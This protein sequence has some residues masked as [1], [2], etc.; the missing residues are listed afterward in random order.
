ML[1]CINPQ[2]KFYAFFMR[3]PVQR[4]YVSKAAHGSHSEKEKK[5]FS[6]SNMQT[7]TEEMILKNRLGMDNV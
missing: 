5:T 1:Q 7:H 6:F 4:K 2:E 3:R